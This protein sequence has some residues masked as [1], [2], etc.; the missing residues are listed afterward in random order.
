MLVDWGSNSLAVEFADIGQIKPLWA[1]FL[2][3]DGL[4]RGS[5]GEG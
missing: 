3:Y 4:G 2:I 1:C 5:G